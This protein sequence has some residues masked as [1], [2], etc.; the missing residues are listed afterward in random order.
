MK[1]RILT[2][3]LAAISAS[4]AL[5]AAPESAAADPA[6]TTAT[7]HR[8]GSIGCD[9]KEQ[10]EAAGTVTLTRED[11]VLEVTIDLQDTLYPAHSFTVEAWEEAPGCYPDNTLQVPGAGL[12]TDSS[13]SGRTTFTLPLPYTQRFPDGSTVVLGDG[14]GSEK[15]VVVLDREGSTAAGDSYSAG[16][17]PLPGGT[18]GYVAL[19]DSFSSGEGAGSYDPKT[20]RLLNMCH[21]SANAYAHK[22]A[23]Y[24]ADELPDFSF[25]ACSGA[26]TKEFLKANPRN[27]AEEAQL[28]HLSADT[29]LV[30]FSVGGN[31][32]TFGAII[33]ACIA[34]RPDC[35]LTQET[36]FTQKLATL[37]E[38]LRP[39]YEEIKKK[40]PDARVVVLGY[41]RF[42]PDSPSSPC[43]V[44]T[45]PLLQI[46]L[47]KTEMIWVNQKA[48]LL[49]AELARIAAS[50]GATFVDPT[51]AFTGHE[52]CGPDP[53]F[54][55]RPCPTWLFG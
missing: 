28:S 55:L 4:A 11:G 21:R 23:E 29:R 50:H 2:V 15:L 54:R 34:K 42:F 45:S 22:I 1:R 7:L 8:V 5:L 48:D 3:L 33:R 16:P 27:R 18:P 30:T 52:F 10:Q 32:I 44:N 31:D 25:H 49:N 47:T 26:T 51:A 12:T 46:E 37:E 40:S 41:P 39:V 6:T 35:D 19:G 38:N 17:I 43:K 13:G 53:W 9:G 36:V 14:K 24:V 20:N